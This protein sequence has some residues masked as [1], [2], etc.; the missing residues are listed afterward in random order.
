MRKYEMSIK[1]VFIFLALLLVGYGS[2]NAFEIP[3]GNEDVVLRLDSNFRYTL[4]Y[5][6]Q[7]PDEGLLSNINNDDGDR[8]FR[9][10][11]VSNR[12]DLYMESDLTFKKNY[13]VRVSGAFWYDQRYRNHFQNDSVATSNFI[14]GNGNQA[15]GQL[16]T[17]QDRYYTG[18]YGELLD[19][20]VFARL[21]LGDIPTYWKIGKHTVIFGE[22][23]LNAYHAISYLQAQIDHAK[24]LQSPG[25]EVKE[26]YRPINN[27]SVEAQITPELQF[28]GQ[29]FLQWVPDL[30]PGAGTFLG[31][32]DIAMNGSGSLLFGV[33]GPWMTH[34]RDVEGKKHDDFGLQLRYKWGEYTF[35]GVFRN[36]SDR[37][38]TVILNTGDMT[39]H[40]AYKSDIQLYGLT[41]SGVIEGLSVGAEVS[42]RKN[43]PLVGGTAMITDASQLP[44]DGH[45]LAPTGETMHAVLNFVGLLKKS[46]LWDAGSWMF[47]YDH[48]RFMSLTDDP[49]HLFAGPGSASLW[50]VTRDAGEITFVFGPQYLQILPGVDL[51][52]P[53]S[54]N[55]GVF[56]VSPIGAGMAEGDGNLGIGLNFTYVTKYNFNFTYSN[57]FGPLS[58]GNAGKGNWSSFRDRDWIS[59]MFKVAF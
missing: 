13:G 23:L 12:V 35:G 42:Y 4:M 31:N 55:Y 19:A 43:M 1:A 29:Y 50:H 24:G 26:L 57:Y 41:F 48:S 18:P 8:N 32:T 21:D 5:R 3:T 7:N 6:L 36:L 14:D 56:G 22:G 25:A 54:L 10:G 39:Y 30:L 49:Q 58:P 9:S 33:G 16:E 46:L 17:Y 15:V 51:S 20:F 44:D 53:V 28:S 11:I 47:E 52:V 45:V 40:C 2:A 37:L 27:V 34:G 59:F 38:P